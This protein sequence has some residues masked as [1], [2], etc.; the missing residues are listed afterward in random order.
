MREI[1]EASYIDYI[2]LFGM[3]RNA[4]TD[5]S[6]KRALEGGGKILILYEDAAAAGFLCY[7]RFLEHYNVLY[8]YTVENK[9]DTG[10]FTELMQ[11]FISAVGRL[12]DHKQAATA[13]AAY[14]F[15]DVFCVFTL[16]DSDTP[17]IDVIDRDYISLVD[18]KP[19]VFTTDRIL[20]KAEIMFQQ[21]SV[22][23]FLVFKNP[24]S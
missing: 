17:V 23:I 19:G 13:R 20:I 8:A 15:H 22:V 12:R 11:Y 2:F 24:K 16:A 18:T 10:I 6:V 14:S 3:C 5:G 21:P 1:K 4:Q 9:R 7:E